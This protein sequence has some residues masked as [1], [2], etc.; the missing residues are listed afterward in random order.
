MLAAAMKLR[1]YRS[2]DLDTIASI[3]QQCFPPAIAFSRDSLSKTLR[4]DAGAIVAETPAADI[5]GFAVYRKVN[6]VTGSLLTLDV[7]PLH[8]RQGLGS[9]L[10]AAC[11]ERLERMGVEKLQLRVALDNHEAQALYERLGLRRLRI[12]RAFY[13]DGSDALVLETPPWAMSW[14]PDAI[15][16][17]FREQVRHYRVTGKLRRLPN[18]DRS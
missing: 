6:R 9:Q 8:R 15:W 7:L 17:R 2:E 4:T 3:E 10:V 18:G 14:S 16:T 5:A 11:T 13:R 1:D 12:D